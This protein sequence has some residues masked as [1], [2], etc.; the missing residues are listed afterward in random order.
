MRR[1]R[2]G[3]GLPRVEARERLVTNHLA[4][5]EID[6]RLENRVEGA[7]L[8][9]RRDCSPQLRPRRKACMR[10]ASSALDVVLNDTSAG[11]LSTS[12]QA[13]PSSK[14]P[15][16]RTPSTWSPWPIGP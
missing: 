6:D 2:Y 3:R 5:G 14:V 9:D 4:R 11:I 1:R 15:I 16:S 12:L 8:E 13:K 10:S 7:L